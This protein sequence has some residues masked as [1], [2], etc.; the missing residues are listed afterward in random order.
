M[1]VDLFFVTFLVR[2]G[3]EFYFWVAG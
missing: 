1:N 3:A 2:P